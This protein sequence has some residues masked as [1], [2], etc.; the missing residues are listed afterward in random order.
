VSAWKALSLINDGTAGFNSDGRITFDPPK[1]WKRGTLLGNDNDHFVRFRVTAGAIVNSPITKSILGR[2]YV[3][4]K[5]TQ[6]GVIP[7]F[8]STADRNADGYLTDAEYATRKAGHDARFASESRLFYPFY[9]QMRFVV[10]PTS[11]A[12]KTWAAEYHAEWLD[13]HAAADGIFLDNTNGRLPFAGTAV[14]E[15]VSDY[16]THSAALVAGVRAA[17]DGATVVANTTGSRAEGNAVIKAA[18]VG[19]EEF[20]LRPN[21]VNWSGF[22]DMADLVKQRLASD[23]AAEL[24]LDSHPGTAS[25]TDARTRAGVLSYYYLVADPDRTYLMTFGGV[26]PNASWQSRWIPAAAVD[27]GKPKGNLTTFA[28]GADPQRL[29]LQYRVFAREYD[30]ALVLFKPLSYQLG[31]G[32]GT[33]ADA[34]ATTH[35]LNGN[36]RV[37]NADGTTGPVISSIT[38]RNGEGAVLLKA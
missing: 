16:T 4:A 31:Q 26:A 34:T 35:K 29:T 13:S 2:D 22:N 37:L 27:I 21:S 9:G 23:P 15:S 32:T 33:T 11:T 6:A 8:D 7:A 10:N 12:M 38:L 36:Y 25:L 18:G 20:A 14:R 5:G 1:D 24:V 28:T 17:L 30:N 3:N 19:F